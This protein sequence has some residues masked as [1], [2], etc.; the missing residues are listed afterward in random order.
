MHSLI[1]RGEAL[2]VELTDF[3]RMESLPLGEV[4][5]EWLEVGMNSPQ[6]SCRS[7]RVYVSEQQTERLI[8]PRRAEIWAKAKQKF[9]SQELD[10]LSD[11]QTLEI[12]A[13]TLAINLIVEKYSI[14]RKEI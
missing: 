1:Q 7:G 10:I 8:A 2:S 11:W 3:I 9:A 13:L 12:K 5:S 4:V 6:T 14:C